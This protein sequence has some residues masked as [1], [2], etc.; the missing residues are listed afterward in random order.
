MGLC[1]ESFKQLL[2]MI[3]L[4]AFS[5]TVGQNEKVCLLTL[6]EHITLR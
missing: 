6:F 5:V 1:F 2:V 3:A 4:E